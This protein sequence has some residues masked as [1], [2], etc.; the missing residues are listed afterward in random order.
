MSDRHSDGEDWA[1]PGAGEGPEVIVSGERVGLR[2][3]TGAALMFDREDARLVSSMLQEG[4]AYLELQEPEP[5]AVHYHGGFERGW[6]VSLEGE[7]PR[8]PYAIRVEAY[9]DP[10]VYDK[11]RD[12]LRRAGPGTVRSPVMSIGQA[13]RMY[14]DLGKAIAIVRKYDAG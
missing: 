2:W 12:V 3:P 1:V 7:R 8:G 13:E 5:V 11:D 4:V 9:V 14:D 10:I 6:S